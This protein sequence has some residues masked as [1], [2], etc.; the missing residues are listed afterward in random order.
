MTVREAGASGHRRVLLSRFEYYRLIHAV[1][2]LAWT[3]RTF[4]DIYVPGELI[5]DGYPLI[6]CLQCIAWMGEYR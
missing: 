1:R 3:V 5:R 2:P 6:T 4:C